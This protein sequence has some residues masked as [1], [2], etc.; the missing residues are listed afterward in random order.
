MKKKAKKKTVEGTQCGYCPVIIY[1][2]N[3][4]GGKIHFL[5]SKPACARCRIIRGSKFAKII[6]KDKKFF[7][8]NKKKRE[9]AR[10]KIEDKKVNEFALKNQIATGTGRIIK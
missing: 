1:T 5:D 10:Q 6:K 2:D 3:E 9:K 4:A 8:R 7:I